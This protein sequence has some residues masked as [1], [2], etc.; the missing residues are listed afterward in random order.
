[1]KARTRKLTNVSKLILKILLTGILLT[2]LSSVVFAEANESLV[3]IN[4]QTSAIL[5]IDEA[6]EIAAFS[7][8]ELSGAIPE[9]SEWGNAVIEPDITYYD[10]EENITAY[11]FNVMKN[12]EYDGYIIIPATKDKYPIL[13]F[14][15]GK[16]P[17]K[18]STMAKKSQCTVSNH[19]NKNKLNIGKSIPIY[20]GA[21]FYYTKYDL[22]DSKNTTKKKV[23]VDLVTSKIISEDADNAS[24]STDKI[25]TVEIGKIE[26]AW[27]N[28]ENR[29][30]G[31]SNGVE[32]LVITATSKDISNVPYYSANTRG[33]APAAGAM[34][35]GYWDVSGYPNF[36][37]GD[38]L[39]SELATAM[40]TYQGSTY[41][42]TVDDGIETVCSNHG[43]TNFNAITYSGT[44]YMSNV[45]SEINANRPFV[46]CMYGG[47][48]RVG[49]SNDYGN[50][51]VTCMGYYY[52]GTTQYLNLHDGWDQS[53][54]HYITYRNWDSVI[55]VWVRP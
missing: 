14:S 10:L 22:Q 19:A 38:T 35:L 27:N 34:V 43:Y 29:M 3:S 11:A 25:E 53:A 49:G 16:L 41:P 12:S 54:T 24:A 50:H 52:E 13:E 42:S 39:I 48:A 30:A 1:M 17:H 47:G 6:K 45:V 26:E 32:T 55:P 40:G 21:T 7:V 46:L 2:S 18:I 37:S 8:V 9:L 51:A 4:E 15:K 36:P 33:C 23:I 44:M 5:S 20:E 28:L 31:E